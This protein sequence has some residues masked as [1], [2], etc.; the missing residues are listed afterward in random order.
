MVQTG[1]GDCGLAQGSLW[2]KHRKRFCE[3]L[4]QVWEEEAC[5][6]RTGILGRCSRGNNVCGGGSAFLPP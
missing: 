5:P 4:G 2:N 6:R 3:A 1:V